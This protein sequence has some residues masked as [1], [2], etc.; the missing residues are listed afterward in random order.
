MKKTDS[1]LKQTAVEK[2]QIRVFSLSSVT[3]RALKKVT[4]L[5]AK[6]YPLIMY[7]ANNRMHLTVKSVTFFA[8]QKNRPFLRQVMRALDFTE[9]CSIISLNN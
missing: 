4:T 7:G 1:D 3:V 9:I 2:F 5:K 8:M 6:A